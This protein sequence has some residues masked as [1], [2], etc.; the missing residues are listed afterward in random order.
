MGFVAWAK[1]PDD[2]EW[3]VRNNLG[4]DVLVQKIQNLE[5]EGTFEELDV[6]VAADN[7]ASKGMVS[8]II[9]R[10][11]FEST[12]SLEMPAQTGMFN[13]AIDRY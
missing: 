12:C 10:L 3:L 1:K 9:T 6:T 5:A 11:L 4:L 2:A 8:K 7:Q 13:L